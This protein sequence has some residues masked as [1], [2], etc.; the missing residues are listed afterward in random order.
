MLIR[1]GTAFETAADFDPRP[2]F[3]KLELLGRTQAEVRA[4]HGLTNRAYP[5]QERFARRHR[6]WMALSAA[7]G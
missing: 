1:L 5:W 4:R 3:F 7:R 2:A 6:R